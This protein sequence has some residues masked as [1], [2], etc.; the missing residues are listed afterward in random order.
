M[1]MDS[2]CPSATENSTSIR[3][4]PCVCA[5]TA[6]EMG[7]L[8]EVRWCCAWCAISFAISYR[9][10]E[11]ELIE[12]GKAVNFES[13]SWWGMEPWW[14]RV[15]AAVA[16]SFRLASQLL[17]NIVNPAGRGDP[18]HCVGQTHSSFSLLKWQEKIASVGIGITLCRLHLAVLTHYKREFLH[19]MSKSM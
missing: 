7:I 4:E 6:K 3:T 2:C 19:G 1:S 18:D 13:C 5:C 8:E 16:A 12:D 10:K 15:V 9:G 11:R 14:S 17:P